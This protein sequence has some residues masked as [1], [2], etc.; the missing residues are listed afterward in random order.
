MRITLLPL[1]L[2]ALAAGP[3]IAR[4]QTPGEDNCGS[5]SG[6][7]PISGLGS[8]F[9]DNSN[10]STGSEGQ[11]ESIC[12]QFGSS[13]IENDVWFSW[14]A[15]TTSTFVVD[16]CT[17][18]S[19]DTKIAAYPSS[20]AG[21]CPV[22]GSVL[23][24]NDDTCA[25][26]SQITF[27]GIQGASY[28]LQIGTFPGAQGGSGTFNISSSGSGNDDCNNPI[29]ITGPGNFPFDCTSAT[30]GVS[31]QNEILCYAF[32]AS[33]VED[34]VWF[35]WS[36]TFTGMA[37]LTTCGLTSDDTKIAIYPGNTGGTCPGTGSAIACNDDACGFQSS[38]T[39]AAV[40][41][42]IYTIQIGRSPLAGGSATSPGNFKITQA[43]PSFGQSYGV[44]YS[45]DY[46]GPL[47]GQQD[48]N[49]NTI[50]ESDLVRPGG[51]TPQLGGAS[52]PEILISGAQLGL[53][54]ACSNPSPGNP[55]KVEVDAFSR[56]RDGPLKPIM[57]EGGHIF[58][59]VD[60]WAKGVP[61]TMVDPNGNQFT[62]EPSGATEGAGGAQEASADVFTMIPGLLPGPLPPPQ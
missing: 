34:D 5:I 29:T 9:F 47:H 6:P 21:P 4:A 45:G 39:F 48:V 56:G 18:T 30:T 61:T 32:G 14:T 51:G 40:S 55:C 26:Q 43:L 53:T 25:L 60:E 24:C 54:P 38:I 52:G 28:L 42:G 27:Q 33:S 57:G 8:F 20:V 49:G 36:S 62:V 1:V 16:T 50:Y 3:A 41:G 23:D 2:L 44:G 46:K 37:E 7:T 35:L 58:F 10:A 19:V 31:G 15:P 59:S 17:T 12:F 13:S 11:N 22:A